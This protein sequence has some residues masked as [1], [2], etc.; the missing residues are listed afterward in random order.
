MEWVYIAGCFLIGSFTGI[1]L[2]IMKTKVREPSIYVLLGFLIG[3][4]VMIILVGGLYAGRYLIP[5]PAIYH[6]L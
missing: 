5:G 1:L 6:N 2:L 3:V 4:T